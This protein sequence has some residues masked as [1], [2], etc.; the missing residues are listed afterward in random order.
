MDRYVGKQISRRGDQLGKIDKVL[1]NLNKKERN[2][3][4][5]EVENKRIHRL[6]SAIHCVS[7]I[8][9]RSFLSIVFTNT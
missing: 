2:K 1:T 3:I 8:W 9:H 5:K 7:N 4:R 6:Q